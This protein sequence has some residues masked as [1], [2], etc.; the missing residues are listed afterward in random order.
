MPAVSRVCTPEKRTAAAVELLALS[1][2][3]G[4][5]KEEVSGGY[6]SELRTPDHFRRVGRKEVQAAVFAS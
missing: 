2:V 4:E 6:D 5:E 1:M 3:L